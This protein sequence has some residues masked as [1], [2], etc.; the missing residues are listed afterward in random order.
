MSLASS[1]W[2]SLFSLCGSSPKRRE[3]LRPRRSRWQLRQHQRRPQARENKLRPKPKKATGRSLMGTYE[4]CRCSSLGYSD[5]VFLYYPPIHSNQLIL[6]KS[7]LQW[8]LPPSP[9]PLVVDSSIQMP[10]ILFFSFAFNR[11]RTEK[12]KTTTLSIQTHKMQIEA[13]HQLTETSSQAMME[14][15]S[16]EPSAGTRRSSTRPDLD[17]AQQAELV[18]RHRRSAHA[19]WVAR[20]T[21]K[22]LTPRE[23]L[24]RLRS[25]VIASVWFHQDRQSAALMQFVMQRMDQAIGDSPM[26]GSAIHGPEATKPFGLPR[27]LTETLM[28]DLEVISLQRGTPRALAALMELPLWTCT[29]KR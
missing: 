5:S 6:K 15:G 20:H 7:T 17:Y 19:E 2:G 16:V 23:E 9:T 4:S 27:D 11:G 22:P 10:L 13:G 28:H 1:L 18:R 25:L 8:M 26:E 21:P 29:H 14:K 3:Q 12:R 24:H